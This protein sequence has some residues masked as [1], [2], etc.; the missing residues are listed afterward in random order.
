MVRAGG[1]GLLLAMSV[2][3]A[4]YGADLRIDITNEYV[5]RIDLGPLGGG[6]RS[7][8]DTLKGTLTEQ[9][10][11]SFEGTV[12]ATIEMDQELH[13]LGM[14]CPQTHF[15]GKQKL[16][17]STRPE[18]GW[19]A[20]STITYDAAAGPGKRSGKFV[21]LDVAALEPAT[22]APS[23]PCLTMSRT[24]SS[25]EDML[26]LNDG[27]WTQPGDGYTIEL[28]ASGVLVWRDATVNTYPL[29][30]TTSPGPADA[31]SKWRIEV[32]RL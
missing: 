13:G 17:V 14:S 18:T 11:G 9:P 4:A 25:T 7:G 23:A 5:T 27:R 31:F 29:I 2:A 12:D 26:P 30:G 10:D 3:T 24:P 8:T 22:I 32:E 20:A 19:N 6:K 28:P 1:C 16:H 15:S 21:S